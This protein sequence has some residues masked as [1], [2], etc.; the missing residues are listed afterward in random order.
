MEAVNLEDSPDHMRPAFLSRPDPSF[1]AFSREQ[2]ADLYALRDLAR[3]W[4]SADR[5]FAGVPMMRDDGANQIVPFSIDLVEPHCRR[6]WRH[7]ASESFVL[8]NEA[9]QP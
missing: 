4:T 5:D 2:V 3:V 9:V 7:E 8:T 1:A 6:Y